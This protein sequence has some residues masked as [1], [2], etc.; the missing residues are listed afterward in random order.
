[1][2]CYFSFKSQNTDPV[3]CVI[4]QLPTENRTGCDSMLWPVASLSYQMIF[5]H[6]VIHP[7]IDLTVT[8][9]TV[10]TTY[11]LESKGKGNERT[12][13]VHAWAQFGV[14]C[15]SVE[16]LDNGFVGRITWYKRVPTSEGL[17][18]LSYGSV[19]YTHIILC[20]R[21]I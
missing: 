7:P 13:T 17:L 8:N 10:E 18:L 1:M 5:S 11:S 15:S 6:T 21:S 3:I 16:T 19:S 20:Y 9:Y 4:G 14:E 12:Y 2:Y